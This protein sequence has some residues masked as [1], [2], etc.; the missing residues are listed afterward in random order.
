MKVNKFPDL[1][2][3]KQDFGSAGGKEIKLIDV[4]RIKALLK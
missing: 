3:F 4:I 2:L 1:L